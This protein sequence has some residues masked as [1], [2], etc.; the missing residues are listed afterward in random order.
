MSR[1]CKLGNRGKC[2]G[3]D[4]QLGLAEYQVCEKK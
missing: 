2:L 4:K 3:Q 1:D